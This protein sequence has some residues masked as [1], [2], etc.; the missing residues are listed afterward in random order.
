MSAAFS[1]F[2]VLMPIWLIP[3][4]KPVVMSMLR[5]LIGRMF[6]MCE[7]AYIIFKYSLILSCVLAFCAFMILVDISPYQVETYDLYRLAVSM[8]ETPA[9]LLFI[10]A[11]GSVCIESQEVQ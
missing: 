11:V 9:A 8:S 1:I 6:S 2:F 10:A 7:H 3:Y 4:N 5:K